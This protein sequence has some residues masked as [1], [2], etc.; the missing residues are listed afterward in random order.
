MEEKDIYWDIKDV[1][2][3]ESFY[4]SGIIECSS[5]P[6]RYELVKNLSYNTQ[7]LEYLTKTL[8]KNLHSTIKVETIKT[9]VLT[10][11][12][13]IES[14]LYYA[15]KSQNLH[16]TL[17]FEEVTRVDSNLKK[18]NGAQ[19][20]VETV[21]LRKIQ[22]PKEME[23]N[24]DFML[25]KTETKKLLGDNPKLYRKLN[26]LRK[27]RNKIHLYLIGE[28]LDHDYN[29]FNNKEYDLMQGSLRVV[30]YSELFNYQSQKKQLLFD[31]LE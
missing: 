7:Y 4:E 24:L 22:T 13:I 5:F 20:K 3:Y 11:M 26:H 15:I 2:N 29:N 12:S 31:F 23:M 28:N 8:N 1:H 16:K 30:F 17:D 19:I 9:F 6:R 10:G 25:K 21:I 18:L 14:I 27:L